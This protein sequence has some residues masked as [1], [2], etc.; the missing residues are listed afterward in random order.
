[1]KS[2]INKNLKNPSDDI[3]ALRA[4]VPMSW[5]C[6]CEQALNT[7]PDLITR[8]YATIIIIRGKNPATLRFA[9]KKLRT[10]K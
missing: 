3:F 10:A 1:M 4:S 9:K 2:C 6:A 8:C 5:P 7:S